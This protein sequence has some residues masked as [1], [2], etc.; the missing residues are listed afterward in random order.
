MIK[1]AI[2]GRYFE[3]SFIFIF[4]P[5]EFLP[6]HAMCK[7]GLCCRPVSVWLSV[8]LVYCIHTVEDIVQLLSQPISL[9]FDPFRRY[10]IPSRGAKYL[11]VGKFCAFRLKSTFIS[12]TVRNRP[13][14]AMEC[15]VSIRVGSD[16]FEWPLTRVSR[17]LYVTSRISQKR[18]VLGTKLL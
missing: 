13:M 10:Q 7:P 11:G 17:S 5:C 1:A 12:E 4:R 9:V 18:R 6:R 8:T 3:N 14:I 15:G 16:D 2:F